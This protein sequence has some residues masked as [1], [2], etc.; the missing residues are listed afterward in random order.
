MDYRRYRVS[1]HD[2]EPLL[3]FVHE[4]LEG[5]GCRIIK[6]TE[7]GEAPFRISFETRTGERL[8]ILCYAFLANTRLTRNRPADEHRFQVKYGPD[9]GELHEIWRDPFGVYT[10][11]FVG[12]NPEAGFFVAADPVIHSPTRF[13]ISI[14]F[15]E[16]H[17]QATLE[18][19]WYTW[20]RV[21]ARPHPTEPAFEILLGG[22]KE[23][24]L[25]YVRLE[26]MAEGLDAALRQTLAERLFS[27]V[28]DETAIAPPVLPP[29]PELVHTL[30][31]ELD[32]TPGQILDM[33][34]SSN[35]QKMAARGWAAE[36]HLVRTLSKVE[37]VT[38]CRR[39][40]DE[41]GPDVELLY[42]GKGPLTIECKN[43]MTRI[44][45]DGV[46]RVD[47]QRTRASKKDPCSRYYRPEDFDLVAAGLQAITARWE[48]RYALTR[49][50]DPHAR[51]RGRLSHIVRVD[52]R[53]TDDA[54]RILRAACGG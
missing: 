40:V 6:S 19:G 36:I 44:P 54:P 35:R 20:E 28:M 39:R 48:F 27:G 23:R 46:P 10:T 8:A 17:V 50:L 22:R 13:F 18:R 32:M 51:C 7:P 2:K 52:T 9:D 5:Q 38:E 24:F 41:G 42:E 33:I 1:A 14:E 4:A 21:K 25:D 45:R 43:A 49:S 15:K 16:E 31:R 30:A 53:W 12:I 3:A 29:P 11:L 47:F 37:G 26:R 34:S